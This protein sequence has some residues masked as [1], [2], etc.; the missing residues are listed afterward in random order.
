M[1]LRDS[2][3]SSRRRRARRSRTRERARRGQRHLSGMA[4]SFTTITRARYT[5][6]RCARRFCRGTRNLKCV[7]IFV[8]LCMHAGGGGA[9]LF[10]NFSSSFVVAY[11]WVVRV[12]LWHAGT[13]GAGAA[14]G[15][16]LHGVGVEVGYRGGFGIWELSWCVPPP[17]SFMAFT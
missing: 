2:A 9:H 14:V 11:P 17:P 8:A 4:T 13:A 15:E 6:S 10:T 7:R 3:Q 1:L 12:C 5:T 16:V